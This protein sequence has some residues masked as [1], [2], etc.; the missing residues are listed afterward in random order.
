MQFPTDDLSMFI[1]NEYTRKL[2]NGS[3]RYVLDDIVNLKDKRKANEE[4]EDCYKREI[5]WLK[6][7]YPKV[8]DS[9]LED[10]WRALYSDKEESQTFYRI[11]G[12]HAYKK[13]AKRFMKCLLD[14]HGKPDP[15]VSVPWRSIDYSAHEDY[16]TR[17]SNIFCYQLPDN[18]NCLQYCSHFLRVKHLEDLFE[19]ISEWHYCRL[20]FNQEYY[21]KIYP[22]INTDGLQSLKR[23]YKPSG[24][25]ID[26]NI[27]RRKVDKS[28]SLNFDHQKYCVF[29]NQDYLDERGIQDYDDIDVKSLDSDVEDDNIGHSGT[30][31]LFDNIDSENDNEKEILDVT[32]ER[33]SSSMKFKK[34]N[35]SRSKLLQICQADRITNLKDI[36]SKISI[37]GMPD[38]YT[39]EEETKLRVD[40]LFLTKS[41]PDLH[42]RMEHNIPAYKI[43]NFNKNFQSVIELYSFTSMFQHGEIMFFGFNEAKRHFVLQFSDGKIFTN[44]KLNV[45]TGQYLRTLQDE[46]INVK[47][48][49][50]I[51]Q[52]K[53]ESSK[54]SDKLLD[55]LKEIF[56]EEKTQHQPPPT[57]PTTNSQT[58]QHA[59]ITKRVE[60]D[61]EALKVFKKYKIQFTDILKCKFTL[62]F[63][64][65][66]KMIINFSRSHLYFVK[67]IN[68]PDDLSYYL[69]KLLIEIIADFSKSQL[70][71]LKELLV[72]NARNF[73]FR[74]YKVVL[75]G[76]Y[77]HSNDVFLIVKCRDYYTPTLLYKSDYAYF[78]E[79][80]K[81][82]TGKP[83]FAKRIWGDKVCLYSTQP[84]IIKYSISNEE[85]GVVIYSCSHNF[86]LGM[87]STFY[88]FCKNSV[89]GSKSYYL[90]VEATSFIAQHLGIP[91]H[92]LIK[93][94]NIMINMDKKDID[95][96]LKQWKDSEMKSTSLSSLSATNE[97]GNEANVNDLLLDQ[98]ELKKNNEDSVVDENNADDNNAVVTNQL[99]ETLMNF[100]KKQRNRNS[101]RSANKSELA[102]VV[103]DTLYFN[104][105]KFILSEP[106]TYKLIFRYDN[107]ST[108]LDVV[109][110]ERINRRLNSFKSPKNVFDEFD[111]VVC[112]IIKNPPTQTA[113]KRKIL[114]IKR[115]Q[116][117]FA[118]ANVPK[119]KNEKNNLFNTACEERDCDNIKLDD[120][121]QVDDDASDENL[122]KKI[123]QYIDSVDFVNINQHL[124]LEY[125]LEGEGIYR[126]VRLI[127]NE[128]ARFPLTTKLA[129]KAVA[130]S[131][132]QHPRR[133]KVT[134]TNFDGRLFN[135]QIDPLKYMHS[136]VMKLSL[137]YPEK[138]IYAQILKSAGI[139][140][141][142]FALTNVFFILEPD[143][144]NYSY[145][146]NLYEKLQS[147]KME[148]DYT[149][150]EWVIRDGQIIIVSCDIK[151]L[152]DAYFKYTNNQKILSSQVHF[153]FLQNPIQI[154]LL[155]YISKVL[156][157]IF[158]G[159]LWNYVEHF[160]DIVITYNFEN[161]LRIENHMINFIMKCVN[162]KYILLTTD[163][164]YKIK[165][166]L[167][168][169]EPGVDFHDKSIE[170]IHPLEDFLIAGELM[171]TASGFENHKHDEME[172]SLV[173]CMMFAKLKLD[174]ENYIRQHVIEISGLQKFSYDHVLRTFDKFTKEKKKNFPVINLERLINKILIEAK[175]IN[176]KFA[177][178]NAFNDNRLAYIIDKMHDQFI[179][180]MFS[181]MKHTILSIQIN[182][183]KLTEIKKP[184]SSL[185]R[186]LMAQFLQAYLKSTY[187]TERETIEKE[188]YCYV[189][190]EEQE[191]KLHKNTKNKNIP[192]TTKELLEPGS[193]YNISNI[194]LIDKSIL[195]YS[196]T[197]TKYMR[198]P[199]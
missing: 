146:T 188:K 56:N 4:V 178:G 81:K 194:R 183:E 115:K 165:S 23:A 37:Y 107:D 28:Q 29:E 24:T 6:K 181:L 106:R 139:N 171:R 52:K 7:F 55:K 168:Y 167:D 160:C 65:G 173:D 191:L 120:C 17:S 53:I 163:S 59:I 12:I 149:Y 195:D 123:S 58:E 32:N 15:G 108:Y 14:N 143:E 27:K 67:E 34:S 49:P 126:H 100:G 69:R 147:V 192:F 70:I 116:A 135:K 145:T 162:H 43:S 22:P 131:K 118:T 132:K 99:Q 47:S 80:A 172:K 46:D 169:Y 1:S 101:P 148:Y 166:I 184:L 3:V 121:I 72:S 97:E 60:N 157:V 39:D 84:V 42:C 57:S 64:H 117:L 11:V 40:D 21:K 94:R 154:I 124:M 51:I 9:F 77:L 153:I 61:D 174:T 137:L 185:N 8:K 141:E 63:S 19:C 68:L 2:K 78:R 187:S 125:D 105:L 129:I 103:Q 104:L 44:F 113:I 102:C 199:L 50:L 182:K 133:F 142:L 96:V 158:P 5:E 136:V 86:K 193:V 180:N 31:N 20:E 111:Y 176:F 114:S 98:E 25:F 144:N 71:T 91:E 82:L 75:Q 110:T 89:T 74:D 128:H 155:Y 177:H 140:S 33:V 83:E 189:N 90:L 38:F 138:K 197:N 92:L 109:S 54:F 36:P 119:K 66:G 134:N 73:K 179:N 186:C 95:K 48:Y 112:I 151:K 76:W 164:Y 10:H 45:T 79:F 93:G 196:V 150:L 122:Q 175:V 30:D 170:F 13:I 88:S 130:Y 87:A 41:S 156:C 127:D 152:T 16:L 159:N 85:G 35:A 161:S 198:I 18:P 62:V 26:Y 190:L